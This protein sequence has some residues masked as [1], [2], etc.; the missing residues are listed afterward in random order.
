MRGALTVILTCALLTPA[1]STMAKP[2]PDQLMDAPVLRETSRYTFSTLELDSRDGARHYR[3]WIGQPP[4]V[5]AANPI[6]YLLD[7]NAAMAALDTGQLNRLA[8]SPSPP[9]LVALGYATPL[10]IERTAR[11]FDYTPKRG[12]GSDER[13]SLTN[14]PSGG[15]DVFLDLLTQTIKPLINQRLKV[16]PRRQLLWGH[17]YGGLLALHALMTRTDAFQV[18]AAASPS[19]WWSEGWMDAELAA[20]AQ[21]LDG[22]RATLLL[23]RGELEPASPR[24]VVK[25]TAGGDAAA[26]RLLTAL[27]RVDRLDTQYQSFPGLNHGPMLQASLSY[28]LEYLSQH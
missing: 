18:Y 23:M 14:A 15:A 16:Q 8:R 13:D 7:G 11:T 28:T 24:P 27:H 5:T 2:A 25:E 12:V 9:V 3:I 17:S 21:H 19:L 10:R 22:R 4:T 26:Q 20:M 1:A 6:A